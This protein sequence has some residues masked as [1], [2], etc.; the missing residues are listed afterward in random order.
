MFYLI[1]SDILEN[2]AWATGQIHCYRSSTDTD[3]TTDFS[4]VF[5]AETALNTANHGQGS[6]V[7]ATEPKI[8]FC[9]L[10]L[11]VGESK[12]CRSSNRWL[13]YI[14]MILI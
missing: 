2:L 6:V 14:L 11:A 5:T 1:F 12:S 9:D 7:M 8:L 3:K 10:R 4:Q 13:L